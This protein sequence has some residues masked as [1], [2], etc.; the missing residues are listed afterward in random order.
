MLDLPG[1]VIVQLGQFAPAVFRK[2][3]WQKI[4]ALV[5]GAILTTGKRTVRAVL[6]VRGLSSERN[7]PEYRKVLNRRIVRDWKSG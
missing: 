3:P 6:R 1:F 4:E 5:L 2:N 7:Y